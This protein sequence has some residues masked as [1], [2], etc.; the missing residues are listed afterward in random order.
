MARNYGSTNFR[1]DRLIAR[2]KSLNIQSQQL[3]L[4]C[5]ISA[6]QMSRIEHQE[7]GVTIDMLVK[8][9]KALDCHTDYLLGITAL[10][11]FRGELD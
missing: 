10:P 2:R 11:N 9:A 8:L 7:R 5:G 3:A 1:V 4:I 6:V